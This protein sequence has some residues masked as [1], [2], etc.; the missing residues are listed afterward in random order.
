M[1]LIKSILLILII[2]L[3]VILGFFFSKNL[4]I[5]NFIL[6][7]FIIVFVHAFIDKLNVFHII[8]EIIVFYIVYQIICIFYYSTLYNYEI[9]AA[10]ASFDDFPK[11][12][13]YRLLKNYINIR[14]IYRKY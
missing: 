2:F 9:N 1:D 11:Y 7:S 12:N 8:L 10:L 4:P 5:I 3:C 14:N 6:I 13:T